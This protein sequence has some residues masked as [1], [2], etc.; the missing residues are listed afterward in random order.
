M[1][2]PGGLT[3]E[4]DLPNRALDDYETVDAWCDAAC[5]AESGSVKRQQCVVDVAA[6]FGRNVRRAHTD[7]TLPLVS[8]MRCRLLRGWP[9]RRMVSIVCAI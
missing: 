2:S 8:T 5:P 1:P 6:A 3:P 9:V 7:R 4:C